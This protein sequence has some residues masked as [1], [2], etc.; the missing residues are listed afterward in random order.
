[1]TPAWRNDLTAEEHATLLQLESEIATTTDRHH[2]ARLEK[3]HQ[4]KSLHLLSAH[5]R[6]RAV[7]EYHARQRARAK[8]EPTYD[9]LPDDVKSQLTAD[10][11]N[12][13]VSRS[14]ATDLYF[15]YSDG[16]WEWSPDKGDWM[17][18]K[19]EIVR[20]GDYNGDSPVQ[21]NIDLLN[22][23]HS[24]ELGLSTLGEKKYSE[25]KFYFRAFI[26]SN[27]DG[28]FWVDQND[29][30]SAAEH[31]YV[32][33]LPRIPLVNALGIRCFRTDSRDYSQE[34]EARSRFNMKV[35]FDD[36][37]VSIHPSCIDSAGETIEAPY[38]DYTNF[39][40]CEDS[41]LTTEDCGYRTC[42]ERS[43]AS[44]LKTDALICYDG[45]SWSDTCDG[46][47]KLATFHITGDP[48]DPCTPPGTPGIDFYGGFTIAVDGHAHG[49]GAIDAFPWFEAG[50]V[51]KSEDG[52]TGSTELW[53]LDPE[54]GKTPFDLYGGANRVFHIS[55]SF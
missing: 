38:S 49:D 2:K 15:R 3:K 21:S 17:S 51:F 7:K 28:G 29:G 52:T 50:V 54:P 40:V 53:H 45:T 9:N 30:C 33:K 44:D 4:E 27:L 13:I 6:A 48:G 34:W 10:G 11:D 36:S 12:Y 20:G 1:M 55:G 37:G 42:H 43:S 31:E 16:H 23:M 22:R 18:V 14:G 25:V 26:S 35:I 32:A 24:I 39:Y 19:N 5:Q 8:V 47:S 41:H 46:N